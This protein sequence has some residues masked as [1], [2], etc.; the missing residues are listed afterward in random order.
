MIRR[1]DPAARLV[2]LGVIGQEDA[3][4]AMMMM[5]M[6]ARP[7]DEEDTLTSTLEVREDGAVLANGQR[8]Q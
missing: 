4:G 7:G 3:M 2:S 8:I 5:S 1:L 6:F